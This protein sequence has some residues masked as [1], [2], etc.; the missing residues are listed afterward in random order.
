MSYF[1]RID[2][3]LLD[4]VQANTLFLDITFC[5][6]RFSALRILGTHVSTSQNGVGDWAGNSYETSGCP[7]TCEQRLLDPSNFNVRSA[8][9]I[10]YIPRR[11]QTLH[12]TQHGLSTTSRCTRNN[13]ST[14]RL[15]VTRVQRASPRHPSS[16]LSFH[17]CSALPPAC[18]YNPAHHGVYLVYAYMG[19]MYG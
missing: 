2:P 8:S 19:Y 4:A 7:G 13:S 14:G 15:G 10:A 11:A 18:F 17:Y 6:K 1:Y 5:G 9:V 16:F 3:T 12:R